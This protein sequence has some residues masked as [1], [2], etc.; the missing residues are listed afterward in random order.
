MSNCSPPW[1]RSSW[2]G[3]DTDA[4][5]YFVVKGQK[6]IGY[7]VDDGGYS[8]KVVAN[9]NGKILARRASSEP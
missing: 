9:L 2:S 5:Q 4:P 8:K 1:T 3:A 6:F 7:F